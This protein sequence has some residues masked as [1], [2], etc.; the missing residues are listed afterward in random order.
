MSTV[1]APGVQAPR[2]VLADVLPGARV[3]DAA[4][5]VGGAGFTAL[6]AQLVIPMTP[7]PMTGQTL[8][9]GLVGAT[10]G[11]RRG[12]LAMLLYVLAGLFLPVYAGGGSG[13]AVLF[14]ASGGYI[15]GFI[16]A[17][18]VVG[19]LAE[20]GADRKVVQTFL[21]FVLAQLLIFVPGLIVLQAV[22]GGSVGETIHTGFTVFIVGGLVKAAIGAAVLPSAWRAVR[23]F[24]R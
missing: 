8:A 21:A 19:W 6:M 10:L 16:V 11:L 4:L 5:V 22:V 9:V 24:E 14:G 13:S 1:A 18:A 23:R 17:T 3:R 2:L 20:R 12:L 15:F 7:V